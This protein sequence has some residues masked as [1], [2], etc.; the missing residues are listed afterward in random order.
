MSWGFYSDTVESRIRSSPVRTKGRERPLV[1]VRFVRTRSDNLPSLR[2]GVMRTVCSPGSSRR[3][4]HSL[5]W[6]LFVVGS[7]DGEPTSTHVL[8]STLRRFSLCLIFLSDWLGPGLTVGCFCTRFIY[9][10]NIDISKPPPNIHRYIDYFVT[11]QF[12][13][14]VV[15]RRT[16][17]KYKFKWKIDSEV[18]LKLSRYKEKKK[19]F[20]T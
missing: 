15:L 1:R 14:T 5:R 20:L 13:E 11:C 4:V 10:I 17:L 12:T 3:S 7:L 6:A 2:V 16:Y 9:Q 18:V 19:T 8:G